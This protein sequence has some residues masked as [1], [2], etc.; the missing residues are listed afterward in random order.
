MDNQIINYKDL[1]IRIAEVRKSIGMTQK[2]LSEKAGVSSSFLGLIERGERKAS[3]ETIVSIANS[4]GTG[5]NYLL[6]ASLKNASE[7]RGSL[8]LSQR[9]KLNLLLSEF[10]H[11]LNEWSDQSGQE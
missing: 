11:Q 9:E 2:E 3:L 10:S 6:C 7:S 1:G 8:T 4:L 5:L